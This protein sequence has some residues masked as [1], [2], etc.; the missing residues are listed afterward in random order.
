MPFNVKYQ[1]GLGGRFIATLPL[2]EDEA[3]VAMLSAVVAKDHSMA[4]EGLRVF[5]SLEDLRSSVA[6]SRGL[7][8]DKKL[9]PL[10]G[11]SKVEKNTC[12]WISSQAA[13]NLTRSRQ[14][15]RQRVRCG[16]NWVFDGQ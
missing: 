1:L 14:V 5:T 4:Q 8:S 2:G 10:D 15:K 12:Y 11:K 9:Q 3:T 16:T 13:N 6:G 7:C